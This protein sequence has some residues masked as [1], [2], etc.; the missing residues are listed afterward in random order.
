MS[1]LSHRGDV[2]TYSAES[3]SALFGAE[4]TGHLELD[5]HHPNVAL[6]QVV[7]ERNIEIV[8]KGESLLSIIIE[9]S[10]EIAARASLGPTSSS[11]GFWR[12]I[13]AVPGVNRA[14]ITLF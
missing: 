5:F 9:A 8:E 2:A 3:P 11:R 14:L 4:A 7:I 10:N 6:G 13:D 12:R 1:L